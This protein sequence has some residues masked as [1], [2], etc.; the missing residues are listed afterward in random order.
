MKKLS[1]FVFVAL[2]CINIFSVLFSANAYAAVPEVS[3]R[4]ACLIEAESGRVIFEKDA[5]T[6]HSMAS[7][8]KIMTALMAIEADC[9]NDVVS[10]SRKATLE[11]GS[12]I[13][14]CE[15]DRMLMSDLIYGLM[16]NSGNDA[17]VAI[18][19]HISGSVDKF[20]EDMT[21]KAKECG[22]YNTSFKNPNGLDAKGHFTTAYDLAV[23][24]RKAMQN[25]TFA[26]IVSTKKGTIS[27]INRAEKTYLS[28]HNRLLSMY[29]GVNGIKTGYTSATGRCLV[30]SVERDGMKF[31]AV[32]LDA[33]DD[34]NDHIK[35]LDYAFASSEKQTIV[36]AG[37]IIKTAKT[38]D[39]LSYNA[40]AAEGYD[41][42]V[43][44]GASAEADISVKIADRLRAPINKGE[45]IGKLDIS[46]RG[47][48]IKSI[49]LIAD[50][51]IARS[52]GGSGRKKFIDY[53]LVI[54]NN[55]FMS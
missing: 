32:T 23:I 54:V 26:E 35:M 9:M 3:A 34:W 8:T 1:A 16:L 13:Y 17:A 37:S 43:L 25:E 48:V 42:T 2:F 46:Y 53:F 11:E 47:D 51:D 38:A 36:K 44:K 31:I 50:S 55:W 45:K 19:E 10:V 21:A 12:S 49:D 33:P 7:T 14:L 30:S 52:S 15:G 28:N 29:E 39:G 41:A 6:T 27:P 20:A 22:A 24:S 18:A 5:H 4:H 40:L